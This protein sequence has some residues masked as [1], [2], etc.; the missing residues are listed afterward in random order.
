MKVLFCMQYPGYLRYYDTV[1][2]G[3][4]E[5]GH[6]V[7]VY[8]E[9]PKK[10]SEGRSALE[11]ASDLIT[12]R[13]RMPRRDDT[14]QP[15]AR[16]LR[17][18]TD[19][20]RYLDPA[21]RDAAYLR[22]RTG[23]V[24]P[25][26]TRWLRYWTTLPGPVARR[27]LHW[28]LAAERIIPSSRTFDRWLKKVRA[29]V[30]VLTPLV[31]DASRLTDVHKAARALGIPVVMGVASWDHLTTKGM[32]RHQPERV[33]LWNAV[34]R[35]EAE[36]LHGVPADRIEVTGA[37]PFDRWFGRTP[38]KDRRAFADRVGLAHDAPFVLFV[39]STASI[40]APEAEVAFVRRWISVLRA[41]GDPL[42][43][44]ALV[45]PHPYNPGNWP[46]TDLSDLGDVAVWPRS[47]ANIVDPD[48]RDD[49]FDSLSYASAVVGINTSAFIE[50]SIAGR[51]TLT[52]CAPEFSASQGGT[53]H[54]HYLRPE[55]G[56]PLAVAESMEEHVSQLSAV[57][58]DEGASQA[59]VERFVNDF[60]RPHGIDVSATP[61]V[62][63]A[64]EREAARGRLDARR[65]SVASKLPA[66]VIWSIGMALS[67]L[68]PKDRGIARRLLAAVGESRRATISSAGRKRL[69]SNVA[70]RASEH[71]GRSRG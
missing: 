33:L 9:A 13:K 47:G 61:L 4:A 30:V 8:W 41:S 26:G 56:G 40:S 1:V 62:I 35:R 19:F 51:A 48:N 14:W 36:E 52:I 49:Y 23:R 66:A 31:T 69:V 37:Q 3:L 29:D 53:V 24:L 25:P 46:T 17:R 2:H 18:V 44:G 63:D 21:F 11:G 55:N 50:A 27:L 71:L 68:D 42:L 34:Q 59:R 64:I 6:E 65:P 43:A 32:I 38:S 15:V 67:M 39:G 10:Q 20:V 28:L 16:H 45:R 22:D 7:D 12:E 60:V 5:R 54:F 58:A 70:R 57:L